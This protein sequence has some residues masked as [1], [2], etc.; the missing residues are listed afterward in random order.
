MKKYH[1]FC[2]RASGADARKWNH[3][4]QTDRGRHRKARHEP[5]RFHR[6]LRVEPCATGQTAVAFDWRVS[7]QLRY[8]RVGTK[9]P[10]Y[11]AVTEFLFEDNAALNAFWEALSEPYVKKL[12]R[13][14][15]EQ[16]IAREKTRTIGT[17]QYPALSI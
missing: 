7:A 11:D 12:I 14:D 16:F 4:A 13:A 8:P 5:R 15:E 10:D 1:V 6:V 17:E 9:R 3:Q 2:L